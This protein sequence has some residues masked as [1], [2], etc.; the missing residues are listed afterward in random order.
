MPVQNGRNIHD[1]YREIHIILVGGLKLLGCKELEFEKTQPDLREF[2]KDKDLS[3]SCFASSARY[4]IEYHNKK[5]VGS[6]QRLFGK[7]LLQHGSI[8]LGSGHEQISYLTSSKKDIDKERLL[9]FI[10]NHSSS[11]EESAGRKVEYDECADSIIN[12][13]TSNQEY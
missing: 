8:I 2:Y 10:S 11:V 5:I 9:N 4:E 13:I 12:Y 3:V 6:A 7:V 1:L